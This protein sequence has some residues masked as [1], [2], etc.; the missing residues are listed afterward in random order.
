[1]SRN[2]LFYK[3][4]APAALIRGDEDEDD[5]DDE[6]GGLIQSLERVSQKN[7]AGLP[8]CGGAREFQH[9]SFFRGVHL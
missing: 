7:V 1:M 5:D 6:R 4:I 3:D 8:H 9:H 2:A